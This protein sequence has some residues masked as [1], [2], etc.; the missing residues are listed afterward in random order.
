MSLK[1]R[2]LLALGGVAASLSV[3]RG[4]TS[5]QRPT[6]AAE[7]WARSELYFGTSKPNNEQVTE[8]EFSAFVDNQVTPRFPDGL[9]L[10]NGYGQFRTSAGVL[11]RETSYV[12]ILFYPPQM[13]DANR[14]IQELRD[15]Y[16]ALFSQES[17]LRVDSFSF[18]SF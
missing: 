1:R 7:V 10:L 15:I 11:V 12:L 16:K 6:A 5:V 8:A 17:V 3:A 18:V 4:T 14:R 13:Q 2:T 9:T